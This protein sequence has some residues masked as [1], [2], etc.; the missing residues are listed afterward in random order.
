MPDFQGQLKEKKRGKEREK[1]SELTKRNFLFLRTL[2]KWENT[3]KV[4]EKK[5]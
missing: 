1:S 5:R 3:I 4:T 2:K